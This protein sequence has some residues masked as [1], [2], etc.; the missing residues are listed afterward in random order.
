MT[1]EMW[2]EV[3]DADPDLLEC[4][5]DHFKNKKKLL[6]IIHICWNMSQI[7][8]RPKKC[9]IKKCVIF[10]LACSKTQG[11]CDVVVCIEPLLSVYVSDLKTWSD[12]KT[13]KMCA[14]AVRN[15][16]FSERFVSDWLVSDWFVTERWIKYIRDNNDDWY[17]NKIIEWYEGY[18]KRKAQEVKIKEELMLNPWHPSCWW[19]WCVSEDEKQETE[20]KC[21]WPPDILRLKMCQ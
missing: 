13:L 20:K 16:F 1:Q 2:H 5:P 17:H 6:R 19:D 8:I 14:K 15:N 18:Q 9:V 3:V 11:M 4:V 7:I 12:L 10:V 21:F